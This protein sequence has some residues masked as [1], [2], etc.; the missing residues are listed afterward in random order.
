MKS[1]ERHHLKQNEFAETTRRV[2]EY[3]VENR[4]M[5]SLVLGAVV[6]VAVV[7]GAVGYWRGRQADRAG[8]L[9]AAALAT[10][11]SPIAPAPTLPGI[12]QQPGTFPTEE[13]RAEAT[14]NAL[15]E[16]IAQYPNT[17]AATVATYQL[18]AALLAARKFGEAEQQFRKVVDGGD[19]LYAPLARLGLAQ[20]LAAAGKHDEAIKIYADLAATRDGALP[21]DGVLMALA[22]THLGAGKTQDARAAFQRILDEF[23][24]SPYVVEARQQVTALN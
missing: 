23:P 14:A 2:T 7:A 6:L 4:R 9:L 17:D 19:D 8:A 24:D 15:N 5:L 18:G 13:A 1:T 12:T 10:A 22:R 3:V 21:I 11:E 20:T 16:V